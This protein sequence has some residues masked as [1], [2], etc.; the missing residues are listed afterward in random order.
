MSLRHRGQL[1]RGLLTGGRTEQ[2]GHDD[3]DPGR[4]G[5]GLEPQRDVQGVVV[6]HRTGGDGAQHT[7]AVVSMTGKALGIPPLCTRC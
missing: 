7:G 1:A 3:L 2:V 5:E 4:I 6:A